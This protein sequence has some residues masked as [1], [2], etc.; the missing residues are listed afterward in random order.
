MPQI[1]QILWYIL[2]IGVI[3]VGVILLGVIAARLL[4]KRL[5]TTPPAEPFTIQ[6]LREMRR[7]GEI[8]EQECDAMRAATIAR[9]TT[10]PALEERQPAPS[11]PDARQQ[12]PDV[13]S[14]PP[15]AEDS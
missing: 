2:I 3:G 11:D 15:A 1:T 10:S 4:K 8:T 14:D 12:R 9:M 5:N 6:D 7:R 13:A